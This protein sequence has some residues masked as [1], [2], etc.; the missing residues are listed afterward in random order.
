M[1]RHECAEALGSIA[2]PG[3]GVEDE[4]ARYLNKET[5]AVV[6]ESCE[7]ALDMADYNSSEEFQYASRQEEGER[8]QTDRH[9]TRPGRINRP[10]CWV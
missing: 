6:R 10:G 4:L 9:R 7:I 5:P 3:V 8:E 2:S 1:V